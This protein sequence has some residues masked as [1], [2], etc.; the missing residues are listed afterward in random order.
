MF[1]HPELKYSKEQNNVMFTG[2]ELKYH[3]FLSSK[4]LTTP[5]PQDPYLAQLHPLHDK[6][7]LIFHSSCPPMAQQEWHRYCQYRATGLMLTAAQ[8]NPARPIR[9]VSGLQQEFTVQ[10]RAWHQ[11]SV[12]FK[13]GTTLTALTM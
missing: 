10:T 8:V 7:S 2:S 5:L 6:F 13:C 3:L 9:P 4:K 1:L 11:L 12:A